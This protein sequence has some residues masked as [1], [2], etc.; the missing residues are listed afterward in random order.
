LKDSLFLLTKLR[1]S[2]AR[3]VIGLEEF[4]VTGIFDGDTF[5]L[6]GRL[7]GLEGGFNGGWTEARR[8]DNHLI[9]AI[10]SC[11]EGRSFG[12]CNILDI[13]RV[14]ICLKPTYAQSQVFSSIIGIFKFFCA[15]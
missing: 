5:I 3:G 6:G 15:R 7:I 10:E 12:R 1:R 4:I 8:R 14:D 11:L 2:A 13:D 9:Y